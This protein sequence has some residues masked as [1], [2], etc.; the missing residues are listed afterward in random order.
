MLGHAQSS[1]IVSGATVRSSIVGCGAY[2]HSY[3]VVESSVLLGGVLHG[4]YITETDIG[5]HCRV[6]NAIIDKNVRLSEG[7][8]IGYDRADDER[9]GLRVVPIAGGTDYIVVVPKDFVL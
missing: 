8:S 6:R 1:P 7:I 4:G 5:R 3:S 9:R 2:L